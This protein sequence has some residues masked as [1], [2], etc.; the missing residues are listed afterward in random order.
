MKFS[1]RLKLIGYWNDKFK[2]GSLLFDGHNS[3]EYEKYPSPLELTSPGWLGNEKSSLI[4]YLRSGAICVQT[5]GWSTCRFLCN[6]PNVGGK[7]LTD[8][9]WV[10]PSGLAHYVEEHDVFLPEEFVDHARNN[11]YQ[12]PEYAYNICDQIWIIPEGFSRIFRRATSSRFWW[13][14]RWRRKGH[15]KS[16][17]IEWGKNFANK[18]AEYHRKKE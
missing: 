14:V 11:G 12:I 1:K 5:L 18:G 17:W 9:V 6:N 16:F 10:W 3:K 4:A 8:G 7:E 13:Y 15:D 2:D